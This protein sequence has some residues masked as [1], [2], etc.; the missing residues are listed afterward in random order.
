M[1]PVREL[2]ALSVPT[3]AS[4]FLPTITRMLLFPQARIR[5]VFTKLNFHPRHLHR[6]ISFGG[7]NYKVLP[8]TGMGQRKMISFQIMFYLHRPLGGKLFASAIVS[9]IYFSR[10]YIHLAKYILQVFQTKKQ[11]RIK[12]LI[13]SPYLVTTA[14]WCFMLAT[15]K[16]YPLI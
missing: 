5:F 6:Q 8:W 9:L 15:L 16:I 11:K 3:V 12:R 10:I 13:Y 4:S 7:W 14:F 1:L 2:F